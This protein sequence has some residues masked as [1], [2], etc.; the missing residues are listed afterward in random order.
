MVGSRPEAFSFAG[1]QEHLILSSW[2][3]IQGARGVCCYSHGETVRVH[4]PAAAVG[5]GFP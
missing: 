5:L 4:L 2:Q 3:D 1:G